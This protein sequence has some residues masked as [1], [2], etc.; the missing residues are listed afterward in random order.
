MIYGQINSRVSGEPLNEGYTLEQVVELA[1]YCNEADCE[2]YEATN[3]LAV[4][5][6]LLLDM[7]RHIKELES[8]LGSQNS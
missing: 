6:K 1:D 7:V 2:I 3:D 5:P 8:K 4:G